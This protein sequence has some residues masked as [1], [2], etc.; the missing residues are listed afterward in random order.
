MNVWL[1]T[2]GGSGEDG[3]EWLLDSV[4]A[5]KEA[6]EAGRTQWYREVEEW[7]VEGSIL[8][9]EE[10]EAIERLEVH[11]A[12]AHCVDTARTLG[13]LLERLNHGD[14]EIPPESV[15][16]LP[17]LVVEIGKH[18]D[19]CDAVRHLET[20]MDLFPGRRATVMFGGYDDD[21]REVWQIERCVTICK[22]IVDSGLLPRLDRRSAWFVYRTATGMPDQTGDDYILRFVELVC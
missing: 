9:D 22:A 19:A 1:L 11:C 15:G 13:G 21:P 12:N 2:N 4:Y 6:A 18:R 14:K 17:P 7:E 10:R 8:T 3:D 20:R 16:S 5:S